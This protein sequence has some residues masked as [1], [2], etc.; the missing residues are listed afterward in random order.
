[1]AEPQTYYDLFLI[2]FVKLRDKIEA[3]PHLPRESDAFRLLSSGTPSRIMSAVEYFD[4]VFD[5]ARRSGDE[6][7]SV[8]KQILSLYGAPDVPDDEARE[9]VAS[10]ESLSRIVSECKR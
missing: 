9:L 3:S 1:M 6:P 10:L 4:R 2:E 7:A 5:Q 8:L